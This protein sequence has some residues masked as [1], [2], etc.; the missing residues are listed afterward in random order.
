MAD[1][2]KGETLFNK[3]CRMCHAADSG[4]GNLRGP[5]L[6]T[7]VGQK[8]GSVTGSKYSP[9]LRGI[10]GDWSYENLN[11][12]ISDPSRAIPG[13]DMILNS[14]ANMSKEMLNDAERADIIAFL[15]GRSD[16]PLPLP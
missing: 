16:N 7:I 2:V 8:R 13:T 6:W 4:T 9:V 5:S 10:G 11:I 1:P 12:F 3:S 15:R 14:E